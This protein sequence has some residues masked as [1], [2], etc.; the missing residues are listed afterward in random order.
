MA[1]QKRALFRPVLLRNSVNAVLCHYAVPVVLKPL[2]TTVPFQYRR[3]FV[4]CFLFFT[5]EKYVVC[6]R[7]CGGISI[8]ASY[9]GGELN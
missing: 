5:V 9:G 3:F 8:E 1:P 7:N 2:Y 6:V 4:F